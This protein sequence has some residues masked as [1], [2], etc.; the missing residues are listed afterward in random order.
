M[1]APM[2]EIGCKRTGPVEKRGPERVG[3]TPMPK[4]V[5]PFW[6]SLWVK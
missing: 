1:N 3:Q 4:Y 6:P 5:K 2:P